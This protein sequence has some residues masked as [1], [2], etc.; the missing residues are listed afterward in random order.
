M[1]D[2]SLIFGKKIAVKKNQ[3]ASRQ[4]LPSHFN[5][6]QIATI[7]SRVYL[8]LHCLDISSLLAVTSNTTQMSS[9]DS[10]ASEQMKDAILKSLMKLFVRWRITSRFQFHFNSTTKIVTRAFNFIIV[11]RILYFTGQKKDSMPRAAV[12]TQ[13]LSYMEKYH[14]GLGLCQVTSQ[15]PR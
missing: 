9:G 15:A 8:A 12:S 11:N 10:C 7:N 6:V 2:Q 3:H 13:K 5:K 14:A 1:V 4:P